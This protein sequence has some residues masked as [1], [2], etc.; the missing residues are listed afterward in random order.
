MQ[1]QIPVR[2]R[3]APRRGAG[4]TLLAAVLAVISVGAVL[5]STPAH[6]AIRQRAFV[7][8]V[9]D[10]DTVKVDL[11]GDGEFD[12]DVR[13]IGV[14]TPEHDMCGFTA[15]TKHTRRLI[16]GRHV[17]LSTDVR[18]AMSGFR[19]FRRVTVVRDGATIDVSAS[20]LEAGL[21]TFWPRAAQPTNM[22]RYHRLA[23]RALA[24]RRGI[25]SGT[26]CSPG[27][28]ADASLTL[29]LQWKGDR[30]DGEHVRVYN[31]GP[32]PLDLDGWKLRAGAVR[33]YRLRPGPSIPAGS[34]VTIHPTAGTDTTYHRYL[35]RPGNL[36]PDIDVYGPAGGLGEGAYLVDPGGDVR[37]A[38]MYRC[39]ARCTPPGRDKLKITRVQ[40][41][42]PGP[43][44]ENLNGEYVEV[45]NVSDSDVAA[46][47][48]VVDIRPFTVELE[49]DLVLSPGERFVVRSGR[50]TSTSHEY[51]L[52]STYGP[53]GND[54]GA[55]ALRT[56]PGT[57]VDCAAWGWASCP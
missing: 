46:G 3:A 36:W 5:P 7:T 14:D 30:N 40:Y 45:T 9:V 55:V 49:P 21:G 56:Y 8:K 39:R 41:D 11:D 43:D 48:L 28:S 57:F 32:G 53:L 13:F 25:F 38:Q 1:M 29:D 20:L 42:P 4:A 34:M 6:A 24:D 37:A 52:N 17:T 31:R 22:D 18:G 16:A 19:I 2:F 47:R 10:G 27:P 26:R 35:G 33:R 50:G 51:F 44:T 12:E 15:A 23:S 54:G